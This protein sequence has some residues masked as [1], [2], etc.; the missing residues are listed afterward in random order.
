MSL[1][2]PGAY[3]QKGSETNTIIDIYNYTVPE[4]LL[5]RLSNTFDE[6]S[7]YPELNEH[8]SLPLKGELTYAIFYEGDSLSAIPTFGISNDD[9]NEI[10]NQHLSGLLSDERDI[11]SDDLMCVEV[12]RDNSFRLKVKEGLPLLKAWELM[13][14]DSSDQSQFLVGLSVNKSIMELNSDDYDLPI[15]YKRVSSLVDFFSDAIPPRETNSP[16]FYTPASQYPHH[17]KSKM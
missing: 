16:L 3:V 12:D 14:W 15:I 1:Q 2:H 11:I 13:A 10:Y 5:I 17:G 7:V 8:D 6:V 4:T 9:C